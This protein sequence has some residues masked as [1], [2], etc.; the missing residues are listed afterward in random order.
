MCNLR[1][2]AVVH[3]QDAQSLAVVRARSIPELLITERDPEQLTRWRS[4]AEAF[5]NQVSLFDDPDVVR[6]PMDVIPWRFQYRYQCLAKS[7]P[8]HRQTIIDWEIVTLWRKVRDSADWQ[9]KMRQKS[10]DEL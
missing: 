8:G 1:A 9:D 3:G 7:C 4:R 10:V 2:A 5:A 6:Q